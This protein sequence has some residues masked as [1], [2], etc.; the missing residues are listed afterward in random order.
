ME[1]QDTERT[2]ENVMLK[3]GECSESSMNRTKIKNRS[4]A[5]SPSRIF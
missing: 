1:L 4:C 2:K 5:V 3:P